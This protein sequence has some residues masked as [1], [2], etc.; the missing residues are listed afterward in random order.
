MVFGIIS[1][2]MVFGIISFPSLRNPWTINW[3][4]IQFFAGNWRAALHDSEAVLL[5]QPD[6]L[7]AIFRG[8]RAA[9]KLKEWGSCS[10]LVEAGL[11]L[12]PGA[13]ELLQIQKVSC[14]G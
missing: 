3:M 4:H 11:K 7:K 2:H 6:N 13:P 5:L 12:E 1:L 8:A 10:K 9:A 14:R